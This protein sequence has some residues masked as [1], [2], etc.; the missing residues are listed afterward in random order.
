MGVRDFGLWLM[1]LGRSIRG[2]GIRCLETRMSND[3][4][5]SL[6]SGDGEWSLILSGLSSSI[7]NKLDYAI[8]YR[9]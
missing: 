3:Y 1:G 2:G 4:Y 6:S 5:S 8:C 9:Y 7:L